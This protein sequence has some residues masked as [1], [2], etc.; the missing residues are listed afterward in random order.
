LLSVEIGLAEKVPHAPPSLKVTAAPETA[1]PYWSVTFTTNAFGSGVD[2]GAVWLFP[3]TTT[4]LAG[5]AAVTVSQNFRAGRPVAVA[6]ITI[7]PAL[8][9]AV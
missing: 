2:G 1:F 6:V 5:A 3:E 9:E 8:V 4:M 7:V